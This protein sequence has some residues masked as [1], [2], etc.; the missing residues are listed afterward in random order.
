MRNLVLHREPIYALNEWAEPF[1]AKLLGLDVGDVDLLNDD[2]IGRSLARLFDSDRAS[3]LNRLVLDVVDKFSIDTNQLHN[4]S[5]SVRFAG[6]YRNAIG[7]IQAGKTTP[8]ILH[9]HSKDHR[10]DLK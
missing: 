8:A 3:L 6:S 5:T 1:D 4:D 9:G 10:P 7:S 2:R